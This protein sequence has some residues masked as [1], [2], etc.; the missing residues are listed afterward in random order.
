MWCIVD[1][2]A[3]PVVIVGPAVSVCGCRLYLLIA[4]SSFGDPSEYTD[5]SSLPVIACHLVYFLGGSISS[6]TQ[7][8]RVASV[9]AASSFDSGAVR[10]RAR[11][12]SCCGVVTGCA[13]SCASTGAGSQAQTH[14][15]DWNVRRQ[16]GTT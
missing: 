2:S 12:C 9:S 1:R 8:D 15:D 14:D 11:G 3:V 4:N 6:P 16:S 7:I 5:A 13:A 10:E